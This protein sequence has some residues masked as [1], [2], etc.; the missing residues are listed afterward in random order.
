MTPL[1]DSLAVTVTSL[2][3]P[4]STDVT[5]II[6]EISDSTVRH[7]LALSVEYIVRKQHCLNGCICKIVYI[8]YELDSFYH[9][10]MVLY[11]TLKKQDTCL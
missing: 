8:F 3:T 4:V 10:T 1:P 2:S 11:L 5:F 7:Y 6:T 9:S